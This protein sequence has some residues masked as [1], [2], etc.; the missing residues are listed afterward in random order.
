MI[1]DLI[2]F[3]GNLIIKDMS[4][5]SVKPKATILWSEQTE[6]L[7]HKFSTLTDRDLY[8]EQGKLDEMLQK[9][10]KKVGKT[11]HEIYEIITK[12]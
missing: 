10:Q 9:V 4:K 5:S 7:K 12:L 1:F 3:S 8:F 11:K 2:I 6:K